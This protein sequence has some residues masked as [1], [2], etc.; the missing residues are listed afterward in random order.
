MCVVQLANDLLLLPH[1][2][3]SKPPDSIPGAL[4]QLRVITTSTA[5]V[6]PRNFHGVSQEGAE[7][8]ALLQ[9]LPLQSGD[10]HQS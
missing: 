5:V 3:L 4:K 7:K 10:T 8:F 6:L 9:L 1:N 2:P